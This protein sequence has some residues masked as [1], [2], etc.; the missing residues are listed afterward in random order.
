M[1]LFSRNTYSI[2]DILTNGLVYVVK[3]AQYNFQ[4]DLQAS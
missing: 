2:S 3:V 1:L 4:N